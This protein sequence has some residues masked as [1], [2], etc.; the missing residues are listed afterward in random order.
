MKLKTRLIIAFLITMFLPAI[1]FGVS[2][3]NIIQYQSKSIQME[4]GLGIDTYGILSNPLQILNKLTRGT[5]NKIY[6]TATET[7]EKFESLDFIKE[8]DEDL[9]GSYSY[10][11]LRKGEDIIYRGSEKDS[12]LKK[13][14]P[15][16]GEF[17]TDIEGG[18]YIDANNPVLLKQQDF[19]FEDRSEGS[20]FIVTDVRNLIPQIKTS[21]VQLL[22]AYIIVTLLT[23]LVVVYWIYLS[24]IKPLN[25][26]RIATSEITKGNLN[27]SIEA[28]PKD[29][30]GQ[31]SIDF[32]EMRIRIKELLELRLEN[33]TKTKELVGNITHDL[34]TPITAIKGYSEGIMD[35]VA[36]T[37]EK[38]KKYIETIYNKTNSMSAL[39]DELLL[40]S[41]IENN[42]VEYYF[43]KLNLDNFFSDCIEEVSLDLELKN[44]SIFYENKTDRPIY[45]LADPEQL[46]KVV[47]NIIMNSV[48]YITNKKGLINIEVVDDNEYIQI[49]IS[50]NGI[51]IPAKDLPYIFERFYRS[52]ESRNTTKGGSGLGLSIAKKIVKDQNG[53]IW[54]RAQEGKGT[55][56]YI[57]FRKY[58]ESDDKKNT[59][60][61]R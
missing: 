1:L 55:S 60:Y 58:E 28:D 37:P 39:V 5:Y 50:D 11:I 27:F 9:K 36:D 57:K 47:N 12:N 19:Y 43:T 17:D 4:Y 30:I 53:E 24:I 15:K 14:L 16:F 7:P 54:A 46:K 56:I 25:V 22:L 40:Y 6:L 23:A 52:D 51:G 45:V 34:K 33:E 13:Y 29:E 44:I 18:F 2:G 8:L 26:L 41:K 42:K 59:N 35:G 48:K 10:I 31:L 32:E 3:W 49:C 20:I 38:Q 21:F 61:R